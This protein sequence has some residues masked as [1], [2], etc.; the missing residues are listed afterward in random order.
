MVSS[1]KNGV[2]CLLYRWLING[3]G[4]MAGDGRQKW[5]NDTLSVWFLHGFV[6]VL[7][8]NTALAFRLPENRFAGKMRVF[9]F[10]AAFAVSHQAA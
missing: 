4:M 8:I 3:L 9:V 1:R 7:N 6:G 10:Q 2:G 5:L